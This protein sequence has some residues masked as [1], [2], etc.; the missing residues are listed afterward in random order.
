MYFIF[1]VVP[2]GTLDVKYEASPQHM[3][4]T[5]E[6]TGV[7]PRPKIEL[8]KIVYH[9]RSPSII[10]D[11]LISTSNSE[12]S[13]NTSLYKHFELEELNNPRTSGFECVL[14]IPGTDYQRRKRLAYHLGTSQV[15]TGSC[16][17]SR[18]ICIL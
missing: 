9:Q 6:A 12:Y 11:V 1:S 4:V 10:R 2:P 5:C 7:F 18:L 15:S 16:I 13:Y 8:Y 17:E 3:N 14:E